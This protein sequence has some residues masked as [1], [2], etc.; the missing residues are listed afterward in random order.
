MVCITEAERVVHGLENRGAWAA[1]IH[2]ST[3]EKTNNAQTIKGNQ[4]WRKP[5]LSGSLVTYQC[6]EAAGSFTEINNGKRDMV[7]RR[8]LGDTDKGLRAFTYF[9]RKSIQTHLTILL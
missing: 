6:G 8:L 1:L 4:A 3:M 2:K 7:G 5:R 9:A